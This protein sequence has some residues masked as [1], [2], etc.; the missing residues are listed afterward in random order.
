MSVRSILQFRGPAALD[1]LVRF[2][3]DRDGAVAP[4]LGIMSLV[5]VGCMGIAI[6]VG[7]ANLVRARLVNALDAAGLAVGARLSTANYQGDALRYVSANFRTQYAAATVTDVTAVPNADK[8]A[9]VL[10]ATAT[11]PTAFMKLFGQNTVT[12]KATT[13][14]ARASQGLE[15]VM[16]LDNTTSM[17]GSMTAL[18]DSAN[19]LV[20]ILFGG[21]AVGQRLYIGLVPFSHTVNIGKA[22][23][24][25]TN[26]TYTNS[27]DWGPGGP[28]T[29]AGCVEARLS[30]LDQTDTPPSSSANLF[31]AYY[32]PNSATNNWITQFLI[33]KT[34]N[35]TTAKGPNV[36]C[37]TEM[38]PMTSSKSKIKDGITAMTAAGNTH[39]NLGAIWAWRMLSPNWRG[40]WGGDM[41]TYQLPLNYGAS[42]MQKAAVLLTDGEN[43]MNSTTYTA[44]GMLSDGRLGTTNAA[45]AVSALDARLTSACNSMKAKGVVVYTIAFNNPGSNIK[46]LLQNCATSLSYYFDAGDTASLKTSFQAIGDSLSKLRVSK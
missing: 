23:A 22:Q 12:V 21:N 2:A 13:E 15:L 20:D 3:K 7:R 38:T 4:L 5:M 34:Y 29:W 31:K 46:S 42:N 25:W 40:Y 30:G 9:I 28:S 24:A 6:D 19:S 39:V 1:R 18:A 44:Y 33:F 43:T 11:M 26:T 32:A 16:A 41:A 36:Y 10:T 37:P 27:L 8:T 14:I 35:I 17:S 45:A